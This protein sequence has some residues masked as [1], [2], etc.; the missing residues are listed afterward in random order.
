MDM[1]ER[2]GGALRRGSFQVNTPGSRSRALL[3]CVTWAD[4]L[5][6]FGLGGAGL[7]ISAS[8]PIV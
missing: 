3:V 4:Q 2:K 7:P 8:L 5:V 6:D 1:A